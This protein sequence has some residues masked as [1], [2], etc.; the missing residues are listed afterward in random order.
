LPCFRWPAS[1]LARR[2]GRNTPEQAAR[3][4]DEGIAKWAKVITTANVKAE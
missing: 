3:F 4:L 2:P 1:P